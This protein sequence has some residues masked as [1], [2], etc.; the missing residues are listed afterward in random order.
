MRKR[1]ALIGGS[2]FIGSELINILSESSDITNYDKK[3]TL[4][5]NCE[6]IIVDIRNRELLISK[7]KPADW[8]LLLAAEH[9]DDVTPTSLYY[10]VNVDGAANVLAAAKE[11]GIKNILFVS[12]VSVYG[13]NRRNTSEDEVPQPFDDYGK[14]KW[15]AEELMR[16]W[17]NQDTENRTLILVR[18]AVIFGPGS[19][20]NVNRLI[21]QIQSGKF[22]M[23]GNGKNKKSMAYIENVAHFFVY[24][25]N[26]FVTGYHLYNYIDKPDFSMNE[27][28]RFLQ[29]ALHKNSFRIRIPYFIGYTCGVAFDILAKITKKKFAVSAIRIKKWCAETRYESEKKSSTGYQPLFSLQEGLQ[30][31]IDE[32]FFCNVKRQSN[33]NN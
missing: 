11:K 4:K 3:N 15:K 26:N 16:N 27:L 20:G 28:I 1:I 2:G 9:R 13:L 17:Y 7:L 14:S 23:I 18:P 12:S 30:K 21:R 33:S 5:Q 8:L 29:K 32:L 22:I 19:K 24:L 6:T 10:D 25:I 31:T